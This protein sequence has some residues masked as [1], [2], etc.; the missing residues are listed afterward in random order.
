MDKQLIKGLFVGLTA[1]IVA[2]V[3]YV[4][5]YLEADVF[6]TFNSL[7]KINKLTHVISLSVLI[8]LLIFF[9]N[10]KTNREVMAKGILFATFIYA[11]II[12]GLKLF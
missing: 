11:F 7:V 12:L 8:N 2:F 9:M 5:F 6:E 4:A 3:I 10:L 1:P